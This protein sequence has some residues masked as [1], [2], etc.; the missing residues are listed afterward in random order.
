ME[1]KLEKFI[2]A[3]YKKYKTVSAHAEKA[4]PS[5]EDMACFLEDKLPPKESGQIKAHLV[6]CESCAD[7]LNVQLR[8]KE[9][10]D[11]NAPQDLLDL[12]KGLVEKARGIFSLEIFLKVRDG[13]WE[14]LRTTG[15]VV[16]GQ[17]LVPEPVLRSRSIKDFKDEI[18]ILKDIKDIRVEMKIENKGKKVFALS[19]LLKEKNTA[20][21]LKDLRVSLI[22]D[23][24]ELESYLTDLGKVVFEHVLLGRYQIEISTVTNKLAQI[25]LDIRK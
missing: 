4:H 2:R 20:K 8:L 24:L 21:I 11:R 12:A 9:A 22:K 5:E 1:D 18:T 6:S 3:L 25:I 17:E 10:Q 7:A 23:D 13:I 19:V 15:D 14:L 16:V